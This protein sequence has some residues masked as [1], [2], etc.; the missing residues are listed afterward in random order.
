M[1]MH[2]THIDS[3]TERIEARV[4]PEDKTLFKKAAELSGMKL[5][6]FAIQALKVAATKII[7]E[8]ALIEL[9]LADQTLFVEKLTHTDEPNKALINAAKRYN[10]MV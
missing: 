8:H 2:I 1:A 4:R 5:T 6:E 9:S 3:K 7:K 10:N